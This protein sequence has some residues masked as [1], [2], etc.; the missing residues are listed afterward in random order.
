MLASI[1][2]LNRVSFDEAEASLRRTAR[3]AGEIPAAYYR[4][5]P[6]EIWAVTQFGGEIRESR[7][8]SS[9]VKRWRDLL[10]QASRRSDLSLVPIEPKAMISDRDRSAIKHRIADVWKTVRGE[11]KALR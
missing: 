1:L 11:H 5:T 9:D 10:I 2:D 3:A 7:V 4:L 8:S 6:A